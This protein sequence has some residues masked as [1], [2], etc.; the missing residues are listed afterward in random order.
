MV[1][2]QTSLRL[3]F[4]LISMLCSIRPFL[5][6]SPL[7]LLISSLHSSIWQVK[8]YFKVTFKIQ[9]TCIYGMKIHSFSNL[10]SS[11]IH[12]VC[13]DW[14]EWSVCSTAANARRSRIRTCASG[15]EVQHETCSNGQGDVGNITAR[16]Q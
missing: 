10:R 16:S 15:T 12:S 13:R 3:M 1:L 6:P 14:G 4:S 9:K 11:S 7:D 2:P 5:I 8:R